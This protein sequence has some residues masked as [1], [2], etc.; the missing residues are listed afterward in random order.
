MGHDIVEVE[1]P[2]TRME[3][4]AHF[5]NPGRQRRAPTD[6]Q[7]LASAHR[8]KSKG[9]ITTRETSCKLSRIAPEGDQ[10][11][12]IGGGQ[13]ADLAG[14]GAGYSGRRFE[15]LLEKDQRS[16]LHPGAQRTPEHPDRRRARAALEVWRKADLQ[17][18][19][20]HG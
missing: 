2:G 7:R 6:M 3:P 19:H 5:R 14:V 12:Q 10:R 11:R 13:L 15:V 8:E 9:A 17:F 18:L 20:L 4:E 1:L 16:P